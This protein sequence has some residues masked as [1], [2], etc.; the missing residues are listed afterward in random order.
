MRSCCSS[1]FRAYRTS[2]CFIHLVAIIAV[3]HTFPSRELTKE[4]AEGML[5]HLKIVHRGEGYIVFTLDST[6]IQASRYNYDALFNGH[7][8][9]RMD[10]M[11]IIM[12]DGMPLF[13]ILTDGVEGDTTP[14]GDLLTKT[15]E[16]ISDV[17]LGDLEIKA[18]ADGGYDSFNCY[19]QFYR[20]L[21]VQ[22]DCHIRENAKFH[23]D[24]T[25]EAVQ[26]KYSRMYR[27]PGFDPYRKNDEDFVLSFL[28]RNGK[29]ELVGK[30]IRNKQLEAQK[31][32]EESGVKDTDRQVC[33]TVHHSMKSWFDFTTLKLRHDLRYDTIKCRF[34]FTQLVSVI[35]KGYVSYD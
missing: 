33:E 18:M 22:L 10:K 17:G 2:A 27:C 11:H 29:D 28:L 15:E 6:P 16:A 21:G 13:M 7:Y 3:N 8:M 14:V 26:R 9:I 5:A 34:F 25:W 20:H 12:A 31:K 30:Y 35:F 4:I 23:E 1:S 32:R 19:S 24:A